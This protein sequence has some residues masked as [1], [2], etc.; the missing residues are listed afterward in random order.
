MGDSDGNGGSGKGGKD[1]Y[2]GK[3]DPML[4]SLSN[5]YSEDDSISISN[6]RPSSC[7][8]YMLTNYFYQLI[9]ALKKIYAILS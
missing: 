7:P 3:A 1:V 4:V 2:K 8:A 9:T 6:S 5:S